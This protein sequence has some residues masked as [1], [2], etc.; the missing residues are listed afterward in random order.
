MRLI[1]RYLEDMI[2]RCWRAIFRNKERAASAS[3]P[4]VDRQRVAHLFHLDE[5]IPQVDWGAADL[6]VN[7]QEPDFSRHGALRRAVAAAWLD[8]VRDS[9][10]TDHRRWR[11][12]LIEGLAPLEEG[13]GER[14]ARTGAHA[15]ELIARTLRP[16]RGEAP[17]EPFGLIALKSYKDYISFEAHGMPEEGTFAT[18]G[19]SYVHGGTD[20][21]PVV[22]LPVNVPHSIEATIAHEVTH[23]ALHSMELPLWLEEG[24]TQMMEERVTGHTRFVLNQEQV[25]RH[26]ALWSEVGLDTFFSGDGFF[27][28]EGAAQE[29]SYHLSQAI[30]RGMLSHY[31]EAFFRFARA[32][33]CGDNGE[34]AAREHLG[35]DLEDLALALIGPLD[36]VA[37]GL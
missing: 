13:L 28:P 32:A 25:E 5:G 21:F 18:S 10:E 22:V 19:G 14:I 31:P 7:Q 29:L 34:G 8:E 35:R 20:A 11:T 3:L 26:R 4:W 1:A 30:V 12:A 6:W 36:D 15:A 16:L 24:F 37:D 9:L 23:H 33:R 27:S 17:I 2:G